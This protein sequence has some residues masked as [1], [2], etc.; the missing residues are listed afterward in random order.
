MESEKPID[1]AFEQGTCQAGQ[2]GATY[3]D[4]WTFW[5]SNAVCLFMISLTVPLTCIMFRR[6][7][8]FWV[9]KMFF[10]CC[11]Q[12]FAALYLS[13]AQYLEETCVNFANTYLVSWVIGTAVF[14]FYWISILI[15]W[16]F[17][18]KYWVIS[19]QMPKFIDGNSNALVLSSRKFDVINYIVL[20]TY[21]AICLGAAYSRF[22]V[23]HE[24]VGN[25]HTPKQLL[26]DTIVTLY[27]LVG[28]ACVT[29]ASFLACAL[30][31]LQKIIKRS[32]EYAV[33]LKTMSLHI[34]MMIFHTFFFCSE[35]ACLCLVFHDPNKK[36]I[37]YVNIIRVFL[38]ISQS[39]SQL[40]I[41]YLIWQLNEGNMRASNR[42]SETSE[43]ESFTDMYDPDIQILV[44]MKREARIQ[45]K[46][47]AEQ[48]DVTRRRSEVSRSS[49]NSDYEVRGP[50]Y[51][52]EKRKNAL[53]I[54]N[55]MSSNLYASH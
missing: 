31:N 45:V 39:I 28:C 32:K 22:Q 33:A 50:L 48:Y 5:T 30:R 34:F 2:E 40:I 24:L 36:Y 52:A 11:L 3:I 1:L 41:M 46:R 43:T 6:T 29:S 55:G 38:V 4:F 44:S 7:D 9:K 8:L 18:F 23:T 53:M 15:Y 27:A 54:T 14:L 26:I 20:A 35:I 49:L 21:T 37:D 10:M 51:E 25:P 42:S 19:I 47:S 13:F 17:G 16:L 12:N